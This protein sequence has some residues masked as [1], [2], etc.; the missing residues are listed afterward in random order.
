ML[1]YESPVV[2]ERIGVVPPSALRAALMRRARDELTRQATNGLFESAPKYSAKLTLS[3][4]QAFFIGALAVALPLLAW[5]SSVG[6]SGAPCRRHLVLLLLFGRSGAGGL[7][8]SR[9][10]AS[11]GSCPRRGTAV[12]SVLVALYREAEVVPRLLVALSRLQWLR[13]IGWKLN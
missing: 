9:S 6:V 8:S 3:G 1:K 12:Y 10:N 7:P 4:W 13:A 11:P 2:R 5:F